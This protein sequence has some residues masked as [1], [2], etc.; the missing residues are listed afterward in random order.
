MGQRRAVSEFNGAALNEALARIP[1]PAGKPPIQYSGPAGR[2][3]IRVVGNTLSDAFNTVKD[4]VTLPVDDSLRKGL[5][6]VVNEASV[7]APEIGERVTRFLDAKVLN[8]VKNGVLT[9]DAFKEAESALTNQARQYSKSMVWDE[10]TYASAL[11]NAADVLREHLAESNPQ[12]A[13]MLR[14]LNEGWAILARI[15]DAVPTGNPDGL[16]TP[17]QLARS[18]EAA[19]SSVRHRAYVR[20]EALLQPLTDAG[21]KVLGNRYPNSGTAGRLAAAS[22][23]GGT[24]MVSPMSAVALASSALAYT[25][26]MQRIAGTVFNGERPFS[27]R[28]AGTAIQAAA[29]M[30]GSRVGLALSR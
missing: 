20:G 22:I 3:G 24:A 13:R 28:I 14:G 18:V 2:E 10:R 25:P 15:E 16:F 21:L 4:Q 5:T 23:L 8:R 17:F 27:S 1:T 11:H 7:V 6:G 30:I 19:D 26:L 12:Q 9:G 29:P